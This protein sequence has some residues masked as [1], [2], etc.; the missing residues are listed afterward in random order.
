VGKRRLVRWFVQRVRELGLAE[1]IRI[2]EREALGA[3]DELRL[4]LRDFLRT[5]G[6]TRQEC[7]QRIRAHFDTHLKTDDAELVELI[8]RVD[9]PGLAQIM[10]PDASATQPEFQFAEPTQKWSVITRFLSLEAALRP[11]IVWI[12]GATENSESLELVRYLMHREKMTQMGCLVVV[13]MRGDYKSGQEARFGHLEELA[14]SDSVVKLDIGPLPESERREVIADLIDMD[15][16]LVDAIQDHAEGSVAFAVHLVSHLAERGALTASERGYRL[17]DHPSQAFPDSLGALWEARLVQAFSTFAEADQV[18]G[19]AAMEAAA[20]FGQS[21]HREEWHE[22][23]EQLD[24]AVP[25]RLWDELSRQGLASATPTGWC[26]REESL[27]HTLEQ[28]SRRRGRWQMNHAAIAQM[29]SNRRSSATP[30][31]RRA[32]HLRQA[33]QAEAALGPLRDAARELMRDG[34]FA[35]ARTC[36]N[37]YRHIIESL[38]FAADDLRRTSDLAM[39]ADLA[40]IVGR[41]VDARRWAKKFFATAADVDDRNGLATILYVLAEMARLDGEIERGAYYYRHASQQFRQAHDI[42]GQ[43]KALSGEGWLRGMAGESELAE[44]LL[45]QAIETGEQLPTREVRGELAWCYQGL[46]EVSWFRGELDRAEAMSGMA[47]TLALEVGAPVYVGMARRLAADVALERGDTQDGWRSYRNALD[48]LAAVNSRL[49]DLA[50]VGSAVT[51]LEE[52]RFDA[53]ESFLFPLEQVAR[54]EGRFVYRLLYHAAKLPLL[55]H[56]GA[57][58]EFDAD[59]GRVRT[60]S[61]KISFVFPYLP[62]SF[63]LAARILEEKGLWE[64]STRLEQLGRDEWAQ[65]GRSA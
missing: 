27:R 59:F 47:E 26:L 37:H 12:D 31:R 18:D 24:L 10:V 46:G 32:Y 1:V 3:G 9:V 21:I 36:L 29:L 43:V 39:Q 33:G 14:Q 42:A 20:A 52:G 4:A 6:L 15:P 13:S 7:R 17:D 64:R 25:E 48:M 53:A 30:L 28:C 45:K 38:D 41:P 23:I 54:L 44:V 34:S 11:L 61:K 65:L 58:A 55:A 35:Q 56:R 51:A 5:W 57:M 8:E 40:R 62:R 2:P 22:V 50:R 19:W 49:A 60:L 63:Q 16:E